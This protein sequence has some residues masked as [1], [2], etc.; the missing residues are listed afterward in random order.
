MSISYSRNKQ[1]KKKKKKEETSRHLIYSLS[2]SKGSVSG[3][4]LDG[5]PEKEGD[6][7]VVLPSVEVSPPRTGA[8]ETFHSP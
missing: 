1:A 7:D 5:F 2:K 3:H 4:P 6:T 8:T